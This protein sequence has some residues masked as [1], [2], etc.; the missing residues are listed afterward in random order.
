MPAPTTTQRGSRSQHLV[1]VD[2]HE[3]LVPA[4]GGDGEQIVQPGQPVRR[5]GEADVG[6]EVVLVRVDGVPARSV[7]RSPP[8]WPCA[9][10]PS[11]PRS[12]RRL[13]APTCSGRRSR[14]CRPAAPTASRRHPRAGSRAGRPARR[15]SPRRRGRSGGRHRGRPGAGRAPQWRGARADR[16]VALV[17]LSRFPSRHR[18]AAPRAYNLPSRN[19]AAAAAG[20]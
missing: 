5:R 4:S 15:R 6:P 7:A 13:G 8:A 20:G 18:I 19:P 1:D 14:A 3:A 12:A 17:L 2:G 16:A 10:R 9:D 11:A